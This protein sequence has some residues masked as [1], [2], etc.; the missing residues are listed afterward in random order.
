MTTINPDRARRY[1]QRTL[2]RPPETYVL[3]AREREQQEQWE[4]AWLRNYADDV[5]MPPV[6]EWHRQVRAYCEAKG[7]GRP[8]MSAQENRLDTSHTLRWQEAGA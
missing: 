5:P 8:I 1:K 7:M 2:T 6:I 3:T 4:N